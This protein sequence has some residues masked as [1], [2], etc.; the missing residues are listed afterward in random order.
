MVLQKICTPAL[1]YLIFSTTQIIMDTIKGRYSVAFVKVFVAFIFTIL[2]NFLCIKGLG[3][4]SWIVVL[5]PFVL[6]TVIVTMLLLILGL[7]PVTGEK[8]DTTAANA[9]VAGATATRR[10]SYSSKCN[11]FCGEGRECSAPCKA[12]GCSNCDSRMIKTTKDALL[13]SSSDLV[14]P[15][16]AGTTTVV[17]SSITT[18]GTG[19]GITL[20][21]TSTATAITSVTVKAKGSGYKVGDNIIIAAAAMPGRTTPVVFTLVE[22]DFV[23]RTRVHRGSHSGRHP[24][25]KDIYKHHLLHN[26]GRHRHYNGRHLGDTRGPAYQHT[27]TYYRRKGH[28][29]HS[30][31]SVEDDYTP[32]ISAEQQRVLDRAESTRVKIPS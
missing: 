18:T 22:N 5:I 9:T 7:D 8:R 16:T 10:S 30:H 2:L 31:A 6:M 28:N 23:P 29:G 32:Q 25:D 13:T 17:S 3:V 15:I 24:S 27:D 11:T 21:I 20:S 4:I 1:I 19:T 26:Y 12:W 14:A